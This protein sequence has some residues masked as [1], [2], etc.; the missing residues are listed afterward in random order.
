[1]SRAWSLTKGAFW[2][3]FGTLVLMV[4]IYMV[5]SFAISIPFSAPRFIAPSVDPVTG[6]V[7]QTRFVVNTAI[8][9]V[10]GVIVSTVAL[11][12]V[13]G[14]ITLLYIDRRMRKEGLDI[15]LAQQPPA[16]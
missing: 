12:F 15:T 4:I 8:S 13:A 7:L 14:V 6:D 11:P 5:I 2:R 10:G 1:M 9:T 3:T 16:G